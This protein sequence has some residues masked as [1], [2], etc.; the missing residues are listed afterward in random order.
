MSGCKG[1]REV[2]S[3]SEGSASG[4]EFSCGN[5]STTRCLYVRMQGSEGGASRGGIFPG[6]ASTTEQKCG[7]VPR[8]ARIQG[9]KMVVSFNSRLES[10]KEEE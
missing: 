10:D 6:N 8:R 3:E 4:F 1:R 7:A 9:S 2:P 5:T